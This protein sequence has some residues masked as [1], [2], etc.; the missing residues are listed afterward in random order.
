[1]SETADELLKKGDKKMGTTLMRW[2]PDY[3]AASML[4]QDAGA[5][6]PRPS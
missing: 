5:S 6:P 1:M 4:Y 3:E 2:K